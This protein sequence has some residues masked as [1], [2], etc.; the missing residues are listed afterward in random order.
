MGMSEITV[1]RLRHPA[2]LEGEG[3]Q[4]RGK[5]GDLAVR[6][7]SRYLHICRA[8]PKNGL[9]KPSPGVCR[10]PR[11]TRQQS[12]LELVAYRRRIRCMASR[13]SDPRPRTP[14]SPAN[15]GTPVRV[16]R[17]AHLGHPTAWVGVEAGRHAYRDVT[18]SRL[19]RDD[20]RR[21]F[22]HSMLSWAPDQVGC[23]RR[24]AAGSRTRG[25]SVESVTPPATAG[26]P[27][28]SSSSTESATRPVSSSLSA[29][30]RKVASGRSRD[31]GSVGRRSKE[32]SRCAG[33]PG[34]ASWQH[35]GEVACVKRPRTSGSSQRRDLS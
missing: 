25:L 3:D 16:D 22:R 7:A 34:G 12:L 20:G 1:S 31:I 6:V 17:D 5:L 4:L 11:R 19:G 24:S 14:G 2:V 9:L 15:W 35:G 33:A 8:I 18:S 29:A 27:A 28:T 30:A 26:P 10:R 23:S 21:G 13:R 32:E